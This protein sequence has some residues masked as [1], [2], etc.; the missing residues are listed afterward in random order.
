VTRYWIRN[1]DGT[2][3][4]PVSLI[5]LK[6]LAKAGQLSSLK[7]A[8]LDGRSWR[9]FSSY[10]ELKDLAGTP[11]SP[12]PSPSPAH[13]AHRI[14]DELQA[15]RRKT[16]HE[17]FGVPS[18]ATVNE[19]RAAF[20]EKVKQ[21]HPQ[22]L[23]RGAPREMQEA[24]GE[25]FKFLSDLMLALQTGQRANPRSAGTPPPAA[26]TPP[27]TFAPESFVGLARGLNGTFAI[28]LEVNPRNLDVF[29]RHPLV[30]VQSGAFFIPNHVIPLETQVDV[31]L[32]FPG[33][34]KTLSTRGRII[35]ESGGDVRQ[36][37]GSGVQLNL[38][39]AERTF[40]QSFVAGLVAKASKPPASP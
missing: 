32:T 22:R 2:V 26:L 12:T 11:S 24:C 14:R 37:R 9:L 16:P 27:P 8:S 29:T 3:L 7:E 34:P 10:P 13:D 40:L 15:L 38:S 33:S 17:I 5:V 39:P 31:T 1:D 23:P 35:M 6:D 36:P 4:G 18:T 21:Y 19:I 30:N 25:M 20:F 28:H